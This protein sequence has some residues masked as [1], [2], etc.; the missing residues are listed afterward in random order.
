MYKKDLQFYK[1]CL[2]GFLKNLQ[3]FSPFLILF[4]LAKGLDYSEIG[5]LYAVRE[6]AVNLLE[7]PTGV[8]AD[9]AGRKRMMLFAF[10][11]YIISFIIYYAA[12]SFP[13]FLIAVLFF[14]AG[15]TLRTGTH[16]AMILEYL[17]QHKWERY[18]TAY[19]GATRA[20][21]QI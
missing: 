5:I 21:S 6:I 11:S 8:I 14:A 13:I 20:F 10:S 7:I 2:Y 17:R 16:K 1:F 18:K 9:V 4:Y 15:D 3:F 19:Y 12:A